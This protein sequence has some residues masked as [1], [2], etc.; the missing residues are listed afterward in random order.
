MGGVFRFLC[1]AGASNYFYDIAVIFQA[2]KP[3]SIFE[4]VS[5]NNKIRT[6]VFTPMFWNNVKTTIIPVV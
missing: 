3:Q 5:E 2:N 4:I 6:A 1:A